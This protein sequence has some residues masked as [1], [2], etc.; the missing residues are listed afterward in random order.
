ML[1]AQMVLSLLQPMPAHPLD[2]ADA[3]QE[4][5]QEG[6]A[7]VPAVPLPTRIAQRFVVEAAVLHNE[8]GAIYRARDEQTGRLVALKLPNPQISPD[9]IQR[10][11]R[12]CDV[13]AEL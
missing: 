2:A 3:D 4:A 11:L 5:E 10:F 7:P 9:R 13:L 6:R 12:E 1:R 8:S